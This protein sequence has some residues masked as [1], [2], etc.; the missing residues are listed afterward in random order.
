V[1]ELTASAVSDIA[2]NAISTSSMTFLYFE[3]EEAVM[4]DIL[5]NEIFADPDPLNDLPPEEFIELYNNSDKIFDL[6]GW[7]LSDQSSTG[8][9]ESLLFRPGEFLILCAEEHVVA[10]EPY[11]RVLGLPDWPSLNNAGDLLE[12]RD[13]AGT[14]I[15]V[16]RYSS[17]WH[18]DAEKSGGGWSLELINLSNTCYVAP[19]WTSSTDQ[20]GGTPG[21]INAAHNQIADNESPKLVSARALDAFNIK[22][23]LN[24][25]LQAAASMGIFLIDGNISVLSAQLLDD[26][27]TLILTLESSIKMNTWYHVKVDNVADCSGNM[28]T[29]GTAQFILV[30]DVTVD[31]KDVVINEIFPMADDEGNLPDA[32]FVELFNNS[33]KVLNM[34]GWTFS[35]AATSGDITDLIL[36]PGDHAILCQA[37][38]VDKYNGFGM[39]VGL[40]SWPG[41]NN[42]GDY[43]VLKDRQGLVIDAVNYRR[44]WYNSS[45]KAAGGWTLELID[46][47]NACSDKSNWAASEDIAGGT[48]GRENSVRSNKP[49][50]TAPVLVEVLGFKSDHIN[51]RFN[52]ILDPESARSAQYRI[53]PGVD[54]LQVAMDDNLKE[55]QL[56]LAKALEPATEYTLTVEALAD[57]SG[58]LIRDFN[59]VT[60]YLLEPADS[61]NIIIN[62]VLFNPRSGGVDFVELYNRSAKFINLN[63]WQLANGDNDG[64]PD[65]I[66]IVTE[67]D[68]ILQPSQYVAITADAVV[69]K[70]QYPFSKEAHFLTAPA[71]PGYAN[72]QGK[73]FLIAADSTQIDRFNYTEDYHFDLLVD[74]A[75]VSLE[76][77]SFNEPTNNAA[78]WKSAAS[79]VGFA[80]PGYLNS[81]SRAAVKAVAGEIT[82][83]P[84]IIIPDGSGQ[85]NFTTISYAFSQPGFVANAKIVDIYGRTIKVLSEND[86]LPA[87][88]FY[89]WDAT[90]HNGRKVRV[91]YYLVYFEVFDLDG[92]ILKFKEKVVVGTRF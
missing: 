19:N 69:L 6:S 26:L 24:E 41:L 62:E 64:Q 61:A 85:N 34:D 76:R 45:S 92:E 10:F 87:E 82:T 40:A 9:L 22:L 18:K 65:Q 79:T 52:E 42:S 4:K 78:N 5:I 53:K 91:G 55:V 88:G 47:G 13:K 29:N 84:K 46:P 60:F 90:D 37:G 43:I 54:I 72:D 57:C 20:K 12:L 28:L 67:E 3:E 32:E 7:S 36:F 50:L 48:P 83:D 31:P 81:Q 58:N 39:V 8:E 51:A 23:T 77:V 56:T 86:Y 25:P 21:G 35:D 33:D 15:D 75:G 59:T 63:G 17:D 30:D 27:T 68:V 14:T 16:V 49:D 38:G 80:T 73:V 74:E 66:S 44:D 2:G 70:E 11:G 71:L 1:H 89:T